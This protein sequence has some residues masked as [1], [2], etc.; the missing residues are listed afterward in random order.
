MR[1]HK[2]P[3]LALG[4]ALLCGTSLAFA[5]KPT[6]QYIVAERLRTHLEFVAHDLMEGRATPSRGLDITARYL[7]AQCK[8]MGLQPA[9]E[10]G[11]FFHWYEASGRRDKFKSQ[12]VIAKI[13]GSD[14]VLKNEYIAVS[15][16]YD[17]I[18]LE[19]S[20]GDRINNGADDDGSGTVAL[21][22][23]ARA[24]QQGPK[25]KRSILFIW[26][27]GEERGLLGSKA[28]TETP[29]VDLKQIAGLV[30]IDMIGRSRPAGDVN[31]KNE[32]LVPAK[33]IYVVGSREISTEFGDWVAAA[34]DGYLRLRY[35]YYYDQPSKP[36]RIYFR[37]DHY[38]YAVKG[39]PIAFFFNGTHEDY[40]QV[41]DEIDK[42]DFPQME[43]ITRT[44][45]MTLYSLADK[46]TRPRV[47]AKS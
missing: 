44:I 32:K 20:G 27:S 1:N 45:Y 39:I 41:S 11:T 6:P 4:V 8:L 38:N 10:T 2:L 37:S 31:P 30:N 21:L 16:H 33:S 19:T 25:P 7:V 24:F 29:T 13:E 35:D 26:H 3:R 46:K 22:E 14:P 5:A 15:A 23:I 42:I 47:N 18:G 9:G 17:H 40:H 43:A 28:F 36:D 12:N 34:N